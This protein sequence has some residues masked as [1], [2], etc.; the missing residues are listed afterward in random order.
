MD[1]QKEIIEKKLGDFQQ[2]EEQ[3]DDITLIGIKIN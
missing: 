1:I 3:R 2:D